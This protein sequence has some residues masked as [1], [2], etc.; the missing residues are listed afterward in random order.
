[1]KILCV[2]D[3]QEDFI[4][5]P[6]SNDETKAVLVKI[7]NKISSTP[8]D[9]YIIY[10]R[11]THTASYLNSFEGKHLPIP[12]CLENSAGWQVCPEATA[13]FDNLGLTPVFI[14][15]PTFGSFELLE[16]L[17]QIITD[18]EDVSY[19]D[20]TIEFIGVCTDICVVSNALMTRAAFPDI[21]I[22]V[23]ARCCAGTTPEAH[24]AALAV[25]RSCQIDVI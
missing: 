16:R 15:K 23:D 1:M 21:N 13:V 6:L 8:E 19:S 25:M 20:I 9:D 3:V 7:A 10:T 12:H 14:D 5:G 4:R 18:E 17:S 24:E 22:V 11:D 2:I